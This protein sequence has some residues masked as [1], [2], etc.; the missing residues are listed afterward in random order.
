M[1]AGVGFGEFYDAVDEDQVLLLELHGV[2]TCRIGIVLHTDHV[3][4]HRR[5]LVRVQHPIVHKGPLTA[6][7]QRYKG[8]P[9]GIA[10]LINMMALQPD[11]GTIR[12][13]LALHQQLI[14]QRDI[15][16]E[17]LVI[18]KLILEVVPVE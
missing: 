15:L 7:S 2:E 6:F 13:F 18:L 5:R 8:R 12:D 10:P 3:I 14:P 16:L 11:Q 1:P 9:P 4:D 17:I